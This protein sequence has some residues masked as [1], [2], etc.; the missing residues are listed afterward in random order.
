M[1]LIVFEGLDFSGKTTIA[2]MLR[3]YI[4]LKSDQSV[5]VLSE[6]QHTQE[7][8]TFLENFS[9]LSVE[10]QLELLNSA[11]DKC[12]KKA[13]KYDIVIFD[14]YYYSS[15]VYQI[16]QSR[17]SN[18]ALQILMQMFTRFKKPDIVMFLNYDYKKYLERLNLRKDLHEFDKMSEE[19]FNTRTNLYLASI[20]SSIHNNGT[21]FGIPKVVILN[22]N[23]TVND[24]FEQVK[25]VC[26]RM[27]L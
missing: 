15:I 16:R 12:L 27:I 1:K 21:A 22:A 20:I 2:N 24:L 11:R 9:E 3:D 18:K 26:N 17:S 13:E 14:R 5:C 23:M 25:S 7:G 8:L 6:T 19:E 4:L 10:N